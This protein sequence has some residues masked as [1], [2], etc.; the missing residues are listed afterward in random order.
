MHQRHRMPRASPRCG[1]ARPITW[2][3]LAPPGHIALGLLSTQ[4]HTV[5][6]RAR[7]SRTSGSVVG[8]C[9]WRT[10]SAE[11]SAVLSSLG[12]GGTGV[13]PQQYLCRN[14]PGTAG[15]WLARALQAADR[16]RLA[17]AWGSLGY[18]LALRE[19]SGAPA[20]R[21]LSQLVFDMA[22]CTC[23]SP[24][25]SAA[26]KMAPTFSAER[27]LSKTR[28]SGVAA[29]DGGSSSSA[30]SW[31]RSHTSRVARASRR[32]EAMSLAMEAARCGRSA[33]ANAARF[34]GCTKDVYARKAAEP[35]CAS[36]SSRSCTSTPSDSSAACSRV[37]RCRTPSARSLPLLPRWTISCAWCGPSSRRHGTLRLKALRERGIES[38][39]AIDKGLACG[40]WTPCWLSSTS[41]LPNLLTLNT[42]NPT[43]TPYPTNP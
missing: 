3:A 29:T 42:S 20:G 18:D 5:T 22:Q 34:L 15:L 21:R 10:R 19:A 39:R 8:R 41:N 7:S 2:T 11:P 40:R 16:P 6:P 13:M 30:R 25:A 43:P 1:Q 17:G 27:R 23:A 12:C 9:E 14:T 37:R 35:I 26:R 28:L 33:S 38:V 4:A 32:V 36:V 24:A 31:L